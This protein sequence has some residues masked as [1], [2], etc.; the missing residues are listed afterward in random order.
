MRKQLINRNI[1]AAIAEMGRLTRLLTRS[2]RTCNRCH[3]YLIIDQPRSSQLKSRK[4]D[5]CRKTSRIRDI[6]SLSDILACTLAKT[7]DELPSGIIAV[8]PEIV[9]KIDDPALRLDVMRIHELARNSMAEAEENHIRIVQLL[10]E[11]EIGLTDEVP[12]YRSYRR[13][14]R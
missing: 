11:A 14:F 10:A 12:V 3:M 7:I 13:T 2:G 9:A 8:Q 6:M 5:S 4:L 1:V